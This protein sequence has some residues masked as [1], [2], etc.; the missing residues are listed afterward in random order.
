[1]YLIV[2][3]G[4][5]G[6]RFENTRHNLGFITIDRLSESENILVKKIAFKGLL[7]EGTIEGEK[8]LL[9][10]PQTYM[11]LS[12]ES[13]R[14]ACAYYKIEPEKLIV[15]YDDVD[16]DIGK[17]RIRKKGSAGS[18]NGMSSVIY[19]LKRDDFPRIRIGIGRSQRIRLRDY[20]TGGF[21]KEEKPLLEEAVD[22]SVKAVSSIIKEG[23]DMAM[24]KYNG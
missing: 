14:E 9:L 13:V 23:I 18:H 15:I 2:G 7:G 10:K 20:V 21:S 16:V 11:N 12:G 19:Q 17:I 3:L 6:K 24:N 5:P 1:M 4:N 8:V 22:K